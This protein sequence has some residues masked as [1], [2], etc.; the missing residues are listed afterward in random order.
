MAQTLNTLTSANLGGLAEFK[1][2]IDLDDAI[3]HH[4]L[5]LSSALSNINQLEQVAEFDVLAPKDK[6]NGLRGCHEKSDHKLE[7]HG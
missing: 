6:F 3:R 7:G 4:Q 5:A 1:L 2:A